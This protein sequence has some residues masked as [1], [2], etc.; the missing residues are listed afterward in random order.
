M[1]KDLFILKRSLLFFCSLLFTAAIN[2]EDPEQ[3]GAPFDGVPDAPDAVIYQVNMRCFSE[4]GDFQGVIDRLDHIEDLG[5]NVIYLMPFYPV[6]I[7]D[8]FNSPYCI[9]DFTSVAEEFGT[10]EDLRDLVDGAHSRGMAV[11]IDWIINQTSWDHPWITEHEDWYE[12]DGEGNIEQFRSY[13]DVAALDLSNEEVVDAMIDAMRYWVFAANIDGFR[14]DVGDAPPISVWEQVIS[15]LRSISTHKLLLLSEGNRS[16]NYTAGFDY[17][18]GFTFYFNTLED[19]FS[20]SSVSLINTAN[21]SEYI[22]ADDTQRIVRYLTNHDVYGSDGSPYNLFGG[23]G[24]VMASFVVITLMKSVPFIYNGLEV[25][26]TVNIPFP[27]TGNDINWTEDVT[28]T[29][30][31]TNIINIFH[32]IEAARR[33]DLTSY[34]T[35]DICAFKKEMESSPVGIFVVVNFRNEEKTFELPEEFTDATVND[36]L[37]DA[38]TDLE[39][40]LT[41]SAYEYRIFSYDVVVG[42]ET[43]STEKTTLAYPNPSPDGLIHVKLNGDYNNVRMVVYDFQGINTYE[44]IINRPENTVDLSGLSK[45]IYILNLISSENIYS[46]KL[47]IQ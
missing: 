9:R 12:Q 25:G 40:S 26:C 4:T 42:I 17:N 27:F 21:S 6:G 31:M 46:Q 3:Y 7:L 39:T 10:L 36:L 14:M 11:M 43:P 5:V 29:P 15:N 19:I 2:A 37:A 22:N 45:G 18:F 41:L 24:G 23:R 20:G 44:N 34:T 8:A 47:V 30:E 28:V 13:S 35:Y 1:R 33:G 16:Q 38:S 32:D